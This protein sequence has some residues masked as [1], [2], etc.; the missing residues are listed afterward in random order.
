MK[1][2]IFKFWDGKLLL[3][4]MQPRAFRIRDIFAQTH[5]VKNGQENSKIPVFQA[6]DGGPFE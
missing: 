3:P 6:L 2:K 1:N 4:K 5:Q